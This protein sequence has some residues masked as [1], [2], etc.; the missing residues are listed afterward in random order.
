[1]LEIVTDQNICDAVYQNWVSAIKKNST[2][3]EK[4]VW[5][6]HDRT[7]LFGN[8]GHG[9]PGQIEDQVMFGSYPDIK[10]GIVKI[11]R[12]VGSGL[13]R[14]KLTIVAKDKMGNRLL[15][16]EGR[17]HKNALS[18]LIVGDEFERFSKL[19]PLEVLVEGGLSKRKYYLVANIDSSEANIIKTTVDFA[20]GCTLAR[21]ASSTPV[22]YI[23]DNSYHLGADETGSVTVV[24][25]P[26]WSKEVCRLQGF[27]W[28]ALNA[29]L[30]GKLLKPQRNGFAVDAIYPEANLLI[31][32]K[33]SSSMSSV[34][35]AVGQLSLYPHII[36]LE[37][38]LKPVLLIPEEPPMRDIAI[39]AVNKAGILVH[40]Y[41]V[42]PTN[43]SEPII[44]ISEKFI[45]YCRTQCSS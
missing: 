21:L 11:V 38:Q 12:P 10:N 41:S 17:L 15:L 2:N 43:K 33:T 8:Y 42:K 22:N 9:D 39:E 5:L 29:C 14:H 20:L 31:E 34:Y 27:V 18:H 3:T 26:G 1:M 6:M 36:G 44:A 7:V 25:Q 37:K 24:D 23:T 19:R 16:R 30:N 40:T 45:S 32:I 28:Q 35:E 4:N 13:D